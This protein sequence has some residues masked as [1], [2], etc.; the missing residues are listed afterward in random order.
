MQRAMTAAERAHATPRFPWGD[1]ALSPINGLLTAGPA[2]VFAGLPLFLVLWVSGLDDPTRWAGFVVVAA[3]GLGVASAVYTPLK[4]FVRLRAR[5]D[6]DLLGD[7][8]DDRTLELDEAIGIV[9]YPPVMY[10]RFV[11]GETVTLKGDYVGALRERP[12]FPSTFVRLVQLPAS[13]AVVRVSAAGEPLVAAFVAGTDHQPTEL[14]G[15][16]TDV[17]FVRLRELAR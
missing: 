13:R 8:V 9:T 4:A 17:D 14:D 7:E 15:Q 5:V 6:D 16:S 3:F 1:V 2:A 10:L 12:D 11:N